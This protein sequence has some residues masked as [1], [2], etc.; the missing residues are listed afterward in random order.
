MKLMSSISLQLI[1]HI[2]EC[3]NIISQLFIYFLENFMKYLYR[4]VCVCN[5][6]FFKIHIMNQIRCKEYKQ[7]D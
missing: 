3:Q 6:N 5:I 1:E 4:Y 2:N 7:I